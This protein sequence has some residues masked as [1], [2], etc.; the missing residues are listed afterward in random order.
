MVQMYVMPKLCLTLV[1]SMWYA[2]QGEVCRTS[3]SS[4]TSPG[5]VQ[6]PRHS[7]MPTNTHSLSR[8]W[9]V[10]RMQVLQG[11]VRCDPGRQLGVAAI[12]RR[13]AGEQGG[14]RV[15]QVMQYA[16]QGGSSSHSHMSLLLQRLPL[17]ARGYW[18]RTTNR[19]QLQLSRS[20]GS[21]VRYV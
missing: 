15:Q 16:S 1:C 4:A 11:G 6:T 5:S 2:G 12:R 8:M 9:L 3:T 10:A 18:L 21:K 13:E 20:M 7:S 19:Q 14:G 17:T